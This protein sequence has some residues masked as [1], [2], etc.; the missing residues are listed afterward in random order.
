MQRDDSR[1]VI[2]EESCVLQRTARKMRMIRH[3]HFRYFFSVRVGLFRIEV[4]PGL[5]VGGMQLHAQRLFEFLNLLWS[6]A[7]EYLVPQRKHKIG[8]LQYDVAGLSLHT[9]Y[10]HA[11]AR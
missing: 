11:L 7:D 1:A 3:Q 9:I 8:I 10:S 5:A 6:V 4:G 2:I